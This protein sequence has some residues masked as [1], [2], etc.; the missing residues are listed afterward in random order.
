MLVL[1]LVFPVRLWYHG[2]CGICGSGIGCETVSWIVCVCG[3]WDS[4]SVYPVLACSSRVSVLSVRAPGPRRLPPVFLNRGTVPV[5][6]SVQFS[7]VISRSHPART[8]LLWP[9]LVVDL[10][11]VLVLRRP[12]PPRRSRRLSRPRSRLSAALFMCS[13]LRKKK[14]DRYNTHRG[15]TDRNTSLFRTDSPRHRT[16]PKHT[17][18]RRVARKTGSRTCH[19]SRIMPLKMKIKNVRKPIND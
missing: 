10:V 14:N 19:N 8:L 16:Q 15:I 13:A 1:D 3:S 2:I 9:V 4:R 11:D 5:R 7:S 6:C 18:V 17:A 12:R